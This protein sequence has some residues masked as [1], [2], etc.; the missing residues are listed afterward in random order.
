MPAEPLE[1]MPDQLQLVALSPA[2]HLQQRIDAVLKDRQGPYPLPYDAAQM[3]TR[4]Q[5]HRGAAR[6]LQVRDLA[7]SLKLSERDVKALAKCLVEDFEVPIGASRQ[8]P[9]GYYLIETAQELEDAV[10]IYVA[11]I[12]SLARRVRVLAGKHRVAELA[13]QLTLDLEKSA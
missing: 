1:K 11:E 3:L 7:E 2:Q 6:A 9:Y 13:G 8:K 5:Y 12:R 4:L 10:Q